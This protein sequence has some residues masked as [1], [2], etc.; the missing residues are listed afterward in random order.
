[1]VYAQKNHIRQDLKDIPYPRALMSWLTRMAKAGGRSVDDILDNIE[2]ISRNNPFLSP[3]E[4]ENKLILSLASDE[5]KEDLPAHL[6]SLQDFINA[7]EEPEHLTG[8]SRKPAVPLMTA[9]TAL[10]SRYKNENAAILKLDISNMG[11]TNLYFEQLYKNARLAGLPHK[12]AKKE[13]EEMTDR[14]TRVLAQIIVEH[15]EPYVIGKARSGGD[16]ADIIVA[17]LS[18]DDITRRLKKTHQAIETAVKEMGL[19]KHVHLKD[20]R[21]RKYRGYGAALSAIYTNDLLQG[22]AYPEAVEQADQRIS[23]TKRKLGKER[24]NALS[25]R[26]KRREDPHW[27]RQSFARAPYARQTLAYTKSALEK[28]EKHYGVASHED[29]QETSIEDLLLCHDFDGYPQTEDIRRALFGCFCT[30]MNKEEEHISRNDPALNKLLVSKMHPLISLDFATGTL[31]GKDLPLI[32]AL[33]ARVAGQKHDSNAPFHAIGVNVHNM[34]GFNTLGHENANT[35][36]KYIVD[37]MI[38]PS[39]A[40]GGLDEKQVNIG[41]YGGGQ[42]VILAAPPTAQDQINHVIEAINQS[43][44]VHQDND[45]ADLL[46]DEKYRGQILRSIMND[47]E[48]RRKIGENG[49]MLTTVHQTIS[50]HDL[51]HNGNRIGRFL[52]TT[53][54]QLDKAV[55]KKRDDLKAQSLSRLMIPRHQ[56]SGDIGQLQYRTA[57]DF[58]SH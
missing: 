20:P 22:Q 27:L 8:Y 25:V 35:I 36:L 54:E 30:F 56:D 13:A 16:E 46:S 52:G 6:E 19:N 26:E 48:E 11:G 2:T 53:I 43:V 57:P 17:G 39:L 4:M 9:L 40:A 55:K 38:T 49:F 31:M 41:H 42:L 51:A 50:L 28:L 21:N 37:D 45:L 32:G 33:M 5:H 15:F 18:Q 12:N 7:L 29:S 10:Q 47:K 14:A 58:P 23:R 44:A 34:G 3:Q 24:F 1:M